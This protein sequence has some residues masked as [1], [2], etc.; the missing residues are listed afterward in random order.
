MWFSR[1]K[2]ACDRK[3]ASSFPLCKRACDRKSASSFPLSKRACD[4]NSISTGGNNFDPPS[5]HPKRHKKTPGV[6]EPQCVHSRVLQQC[7][8]PSAQ[9]L[10]SAPL[11]VSSPQCHDRPSAQGRPSTHTE[12]AEQTKSSLR[13]QGR[14]SAHTEFAGWT[15]YLPTSSTQGRPSVHTEYTE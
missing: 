6:L 3:S 4:R 10:Q 9:A 15:K 13:T 2:R 14:P 7:S 5:R 12:C 8:A 11:E 1:S